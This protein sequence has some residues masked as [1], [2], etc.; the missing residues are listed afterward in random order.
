MSFRIFTV[1]E[2]FFRVVFAQV[3]TGL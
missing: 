2:H 3:W 1:I